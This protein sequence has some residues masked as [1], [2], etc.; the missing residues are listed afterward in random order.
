MAYADLAQLNLEDDRL[1]YSGVS[2]LKIRDTIFMFEG[3]RDIYLKDIVYYELIVEN[4]K[5]RME[6]KCRVCQDKEANILILPCAHVT[7]C[8]LCT[9]YILKCPNCNSKIKATVKVYFA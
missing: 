6:R 4:E 7:L 9:P 3:T 8:T 2:E 1:I 5:I